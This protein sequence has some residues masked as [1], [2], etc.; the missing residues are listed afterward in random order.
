MEEKLDTLIE[1]FGEFSNTLIEI[2]STVNDFT[3]RLESLETKLTELSTKTPKSKKAAASIEEQLIKQ[4]NPIK[5]IHAKRITSQTKNEYKENVD[6]FLERYNISRD[7]YDEAVKN[8][9]DSLDNQFSEIHTKYK[10]EINEIYHQLNQVNENSNDSVN[11]TE[12]IVKTAKKTTSS[13]KKS[14][15]KTTKTTDSENTDENDQ[16]DDD[17]NKI[18][19]ST[20]TT[21]STKKTS[22]SSKST[23][24]TTD[25][26][27]ST[28]KK[29]KIKKTQRENEFDL[30]D[31]DTDVNSVMNAANEADEEAEDMPM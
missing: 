19:K 7:D 30:P 28:K 29:R 12:T 14:A 24:K 11:K 4:T 2:Q 9:P 17:D 22:D 23:K 13:V 21:K 26:N 3:H 25:S 18:V 27:K 10:V 6:T 31:E 1:Q 5:K 16:D 8:H 20:K 15:K